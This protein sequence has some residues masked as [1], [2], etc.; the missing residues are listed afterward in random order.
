MFSANRSELTETVCEKTRPACNACCYLEKQLNE[1]EN[2]SVPYENP[3][4]SGK[5]A[6]EVKIMDYT[7]AV[8]NIDL[9]KRIKTNL[10]TA[11]QNIQS[12]FFAREIFHPPELLS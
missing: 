2:E 5:K 12:L 11:D 6:P 8:F 4:R 1:S 7:P 9:L 3:Q 10:F